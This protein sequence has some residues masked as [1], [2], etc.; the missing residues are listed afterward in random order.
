MSEKKERKDT[1]TLT[2]KLA[3][4]LMPYLDA[5][6]KIKPMPLQISY[7][8]GKIHRKLKAE[9]G[10]YQDKQQDLIKELGAEI[11]VKKEMR[12]TAD[13]LGRD[14]KPGEESQILRMKGSYRVGPE[15]QEEYQAQVTATIEEEIVLTGVKRPE[16]KLSDYDEEK[17][18]EVEGKN[19]GGLN[20]GAIIAGLEPELME[21][22]E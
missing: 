6:I 4:T 7:R 9:L 16:I 19:D 8:A 22:V 5:F 18:E 21:I 2:V 13:T 20:F 14:L 17:I 15:K 3:D 11:D 12:E 1:I 10:D